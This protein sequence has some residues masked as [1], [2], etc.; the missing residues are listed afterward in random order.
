MKV[1]IIGSGVVGQAL[2]T[3]FARLGHEVVLGTRDPGS[4]K[5]KGWVAKAGPKASAG[6]FEQAA[7]AG[8]LVALATLWSG[9]AS[10]IR[11]A[12]PR[13]FVDKVVID[14]TNPL[15]FP[16]NAPPTLA[17][18]GTDSGG[19]QVQ[20]LLPGAKV[21]KAFNIITNAA[22][23]RPQYQGGPPTMFICGNDD[24]AKRTVLGICY[25]FG[26]PESYDIGG[27]EGA[28]LLE[29]LAML[30]VLHGARSGSWDHAFK[31]IRKS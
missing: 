3:G 8:E 14:V 29:P 2:G 22:M 7:V 31:L 23:F 12:G 18:S 28:R 10:A 25:D 15:A 11:M 24:A 4:D 9:T 13:N 1:G 6:T 27:I 26:W 30:W 5:V 16:P 20:R 21:V 19:E 17:V